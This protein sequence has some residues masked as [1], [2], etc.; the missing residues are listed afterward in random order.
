MEEQALSSCIVSLIFVQVVPLIIN[1][2]QGYS[3]SRLMVKMQ[4]V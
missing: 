4:S 2:D 3:V 1:P